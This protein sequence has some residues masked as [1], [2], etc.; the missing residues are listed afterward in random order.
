M[1]NIL[2]FIEKRKWGIIA[3]FML[4]LG[5]LLYLQVETYSTLLPG[6]N[7]DMMSEVIAE[8]DFI[9]LNPDQILSNEMNPSNDI[10]NITRDVNDSRDRSS[11]DYNSHYTDTDIDQQVRDLEQQYFNEFQ[12]SRDESGQN[13][14]QSATPVTTPSPVK[15]NKQNVTQST[16]SN[17]NNQYSGGNVMVDYQV[18]SKE[19]KPHNNNLW[20]VRNPGYTCGG[21]SNGKVY[22]SIKVNQNGDVYQAKY[23]PEKSQNATQC[24]IDQ[25]LVY[26]YKSRFEYDKGTSTQE[27]GWILYTFV[28]KK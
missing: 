3:T 16:N 1:E 7:N 10:R 14:Q 2:D 6:R 24:M 21:G 18:G 4:H 25:A 22:V 12:Q 17:S 26:A 15:P 20:Y 5:G 19:R 11:T 8:E 28:S 23:I 9:E 27:N 13:G